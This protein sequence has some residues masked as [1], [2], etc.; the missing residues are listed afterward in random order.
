[1]GYKI[2]NGLEDVDK[3]ER[4]YINATTNYLSINNGN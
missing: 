2:K 1:M 4:A 3:T